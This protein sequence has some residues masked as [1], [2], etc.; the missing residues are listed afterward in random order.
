[1][2]VLCPEAS[3]ESLVTV[4]LENGVVAGFDDS[5]VSGGF[6]ELG[7]VLS[8][9]RADGEVYLSL[10]DDFLGRV[11]VL[12]DEVAGVA[13]EHHGF[14]CPLG[15]AADFDQLVL[16]PLM[17]AVRAFSMTPSKWR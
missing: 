13:G 6:G 9:V 7:V 4:V 15:T 3:V 12:N 17:Q 16:Q 11:R 2:D 5:R 14:Q 10:R 1:M 8:Q